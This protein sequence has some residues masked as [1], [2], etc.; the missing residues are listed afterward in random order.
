MYH[1]SAVVAAK[2]GDAEASW[3]EKNNDTLDPG[4]LQAMVDSSVPMLKDMF[5]KEHD[6]AQK[7]TKKASFSS[8]S[9]RFVNDLNS[10]LGE[11]GAAKVSFIRCVKPNMEQKAGIFTQSMVRDQPTRT[12][13]LAPGP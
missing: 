10:L 6:E 4:W 8:V 1:S 2:T 5:I 13:T 3:L 7:A 11:L 9:K 12:L